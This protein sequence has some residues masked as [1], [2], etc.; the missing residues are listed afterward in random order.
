M[1]LILESKT[2]Q[3]LVPIQRYGHWLHHTIG[4]LP[5]EAES[6]TDLTKYN[7]MVISEDKSVSALLITQRFVRIMQE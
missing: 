5:P 6:R 1:Y 4:Y 7:G 2:D 3:E